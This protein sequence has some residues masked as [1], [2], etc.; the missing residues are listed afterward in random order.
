MQLCHC[1]WTIFGHNFYTITFTDQSK[2]EKVIM[3]QKF[4]SSLLLDMKATENNLG[5]IFF[6]YV[7][8]TTTCLPEFK[9]SE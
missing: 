4:H 5:T 7:L 8:S 2:F 6:F 1:G 3:K 9:N